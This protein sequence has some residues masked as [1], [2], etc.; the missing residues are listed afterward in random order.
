MGYTFHN[1]FGCHD[2]NDQPYPAVAV[3]LSRWFAPCK[4]N[5]RQTYAPLGNPRQEFGK[6]YFFSK[7]IMGHCAKSLYLLVKKRCSMVKNAL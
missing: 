2:R 1:Y 7:N 5:L 6:N 3:L 4:A